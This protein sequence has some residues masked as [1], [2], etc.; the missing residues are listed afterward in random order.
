MTTQCHTR[1]EVDDIRNFIDSANNISS[2]TFLRQ[3]QLATLQVWGRSYVFAGGRR[4][5]KIEGFTNLVEAERVQRDYCLFVSTGRGNLKTL[6]K[7]EEQM[8]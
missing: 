4:L 5:R 7:L 8:E 6:R 2:A 1:E 3:R